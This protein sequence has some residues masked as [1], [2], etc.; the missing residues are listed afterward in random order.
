MKESIVRGDV[1]YELCTEG[2]KYVIRRTERKGDRVVMT[3]TARGCQRDAE[4]VW[5]RIVHALP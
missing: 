4:A 1:E 2:G 3:E 5:V